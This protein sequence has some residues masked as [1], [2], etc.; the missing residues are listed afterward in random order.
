MKPTLHPTQ[1]SPAIALAQLLSENP[2]LPALMWEIRPNG[3]LNGRLWVDDSR[4]ASAAYRDALGV[5]YVLTLEY[6]VRGVPMVSEDMSTVWRDVSVHL[7]FRS[8][9]AAHL[10]A[11]A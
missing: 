9:A 6:S 1:L 4:A 10:G 11:A 2:H 3:E 8:L 5:G 7:S